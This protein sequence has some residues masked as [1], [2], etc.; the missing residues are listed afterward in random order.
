[1]SKRARYW[2][3]VCQNCIGWYGR[4]ALLR[5]RRDSVEY[6]DDHRDMWCMYHSESNKFELVPCVGTPYEKARRK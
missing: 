2:V 5:K 6:W 4:L 1:M 3:C